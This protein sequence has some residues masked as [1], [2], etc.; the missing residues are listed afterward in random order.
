MV[1]DGGVWTY[2]VDADCLSTYKM[3]ITAFSGEWYVGKVDEHLKE[4]GGKYGHLNIGDS[5]AYVP[6]RIVERH[7]C[8]KHHLCS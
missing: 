3:G 4:R 5:P 2:D 1:A 7:V 8:R 6:T